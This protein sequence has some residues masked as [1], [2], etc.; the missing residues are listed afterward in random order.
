MLAFEWYNQIDA[1]YARESAYAMTEMKL[2]EY[3]GV[4]NSLK[5]D[6]TYLILVHV[7]K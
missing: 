6:V 7:Q 3:S 5:L 2:K 1:G 4:H